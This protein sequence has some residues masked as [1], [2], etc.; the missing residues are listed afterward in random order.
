MELRTVGFDHPD[1]QTLTEQVQQE[2]VVRYGGI[3]RSPIDPREFD[4][5]TGLF[6]VGYLDGRPV[7]CAGWRTPPYT[8][9]WPGDA[10]VKRM[11]VAP[12]A[13]G[14]GLA[15]RM[16]AALE[17][18]AAAAGKTRMVLETGLG[19]P[20]AITLY[21]SAGYAPIPSFGL[22]RDSPG[23][24]CYARSLATGTDPAPEQ[25]GGAQR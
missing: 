25:V 21:L 22:H 10:E 2:Y 17:R 8:L 20:E 11:Y 13:R 12:E 18:D 19:Q 15:R 6:L 7:G 3:D 14:R 24:R 4:P 9:L 16:L 5:P 23:N 1:A